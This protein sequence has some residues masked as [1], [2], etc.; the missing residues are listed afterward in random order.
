MT[1]SAF[2]PLHIIYRYSVSV[3]PN[4]TKLHFVSNLVLFTEFARSLLDV[5]SVWPNIS[6]KVLDIQCGILFMIYQTITSG[7][8][9]KNLLIGS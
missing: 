1:F 3:E 6:I 5:T 2:N 8:N 7:F 9:N 4:L